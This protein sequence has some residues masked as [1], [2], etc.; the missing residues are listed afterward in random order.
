MR[1]KRP[2]HIFFLVRIQCYS[3]QIVFVSLFNCVVDVCYENTYQWHLDFLLCT[4]VRAHTH[5]THT[6]TLTSCW[7]Y[8]GGL[9]H[10][11][12]DQNFT[13]WW[14]KRICFCCFFPQSLTQCQSQLLKTFSVIF[15][16]ATIIQR[17]RTML[18]VKQMNWFCKWSKCEECRKVIDL[19]FI[20]CG[21]TQWEL[22]W[23]LSQL[24]TEPY[25]EHQSITG[26]W[27]TAHWARI[28][29]LTS[30]TK[31]SYVKHDITTGPF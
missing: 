20:A 12:P 4:D 19:C 24:R 15:L 25:I 14:V 1:C 29:P 3:K 13:S 9:L 21:G 2:I 23:N 10:F 27:W 7:V 22:S 26:R 8:R 16:A 18:W 11:E 31:E 6:D 17:S 30:C 5:T 28:D